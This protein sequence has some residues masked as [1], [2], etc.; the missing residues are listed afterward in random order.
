MEGPPST[1]LT[2]PSPSMLLLLF[3]RADLMGS[4]RWTKLGRFLGGL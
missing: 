2:Q 1:S 4:A 3:T